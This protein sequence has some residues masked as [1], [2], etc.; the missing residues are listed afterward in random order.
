MDTAWNLIVRNRSYRLLLGASLI[1]LSGDWIFSIGMAFY[2]YAMTGSALASGAIVFAALLP[3]FLLGSVAGVFVD[4]WDRR[5]T[6]VATNVALALSLVPVLFVHGAGQLWIVYL[7][8]VA[9]NS[10]AQLFTS[11]EAAFVPAVVPRDQLIVANA[12]NGQN[13][14]IARLAGSALGGLLAAVGGLV[15]VTVANMASYAL[16]A[17]LIAMIPARTGARPDTVAEPGATGGARRPW[18][19]WVDGIRL[20]GR[21]PDLSALLVYRMT[22]RLGEGVLSALF[23]PFLIG[24]VQASAAEYGAVNGIQAVGGITGGAVIAIL[25]ARARPVELLGFGTLLAGVILLLFSTYPLALSG[26]WPAFLLI[27]VIGLPMAA[28]NAGFY[29]LVQL[30]SR[31]DARGRVFGATSAAAAAAMLVGSVVGSTLGTGIGVIPVLSVDGVICVIA[32]PLV[33]ARLRQ[34]SRRRAAEV[35][36]AAAAATESRS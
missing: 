18:R 12:L 6:M 21:D 13:S 3:Q 19:E 22:T 28:V 16:A 35:A 14:H 8:V 30:R 29:T 11:A 24:V 7:T 31:E 33:L 36:L 27:A 23:A 20:C 32:G 15:T 25:A 26:V 34:I 1:S 17:G 10:I 4:R 9:Q 5:L 2:V